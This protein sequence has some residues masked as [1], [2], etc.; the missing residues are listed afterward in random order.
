MIINNRDVKLFFSIG[1]HAEISDRCPGHS[2]KNLSEYLA[3]N[4]TRA[5]CDMALIM[6]RAYHA[7]HPEDETA[8]LTREELENMP[9]WQFNE[10]DTAVGS[11]MKDGGRVTVE[12]EDTKGKKKEQV[13]RS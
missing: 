8:P 6:N 5:V 13:S 4:Y 3:G 12:T 2:F 11:A 1:A 7:A 10:L 9:Q